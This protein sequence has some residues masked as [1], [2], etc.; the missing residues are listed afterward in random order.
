[1]KE[2]DIK[3][4]TI[5][6]MKAGIDAVLSGK[7]TIF[8]S[9]FIPP[10]LVEDYLVKLGWEKGE[11]DTNGWEYDWWLPFTKDGK[12]FTASGGGFY[13]NFEFSETEA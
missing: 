3:K 5:E 1:M 9:F 4:E 13:G 12:S 6:R 2:P 10:E 7:A 11:F 8:K